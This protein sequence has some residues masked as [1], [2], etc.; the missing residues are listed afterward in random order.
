MGNRINS[1]HGSVKLFLVFNKH[2]EPLILGIPMDSDVQETE[3][4]LKDFGLWPVDAHG[5]SY[6]ACKRPAALELFAMD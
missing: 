3:Q 4:K 6:P 1:K 2:T 5:K